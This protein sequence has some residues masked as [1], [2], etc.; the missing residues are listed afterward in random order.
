MVTATVEHTYFKG[1]DEIATFIDIIEHPENYYLDED[2]S[3][4]R[5]S[6]NELVIPGAMYYKFNIHTFDALQHIGDN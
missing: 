4:I 5:K 1:T 2:N 6:D 3:V